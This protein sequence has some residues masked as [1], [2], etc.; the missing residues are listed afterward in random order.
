MNRYRKQPSEEEL[1]AQT[2]RSPHPKPTI[3]PKEKPLTTRV[4]PVTVEPPLTP[5][6]FAWEVLSTNLFEGLS[7]MVGGYIPQVPL[8]KIKS[9]LF[10]SPVLVASDLHK[11]GLVIFSQMTKLLNAKEH[12]VILCGDM[13]G[14][15]KRGEDASITPLFNFLQ[16]EYRSLH[17]VHGNH[18]IAETE[19]RSNPDGS[20]CQLDDAPRMVAGRRVCGVSGV[21]GTTK[22]RHRLLP[23]RFVSRV[24]AALLEDP[25]NS[26]LCTHETPELQVFTPPI[27]QEML[28][29]VVCEL[30][31]KAHFFGHC[32]LKP[33]Q[34][35]FAKTLF[36]NAD[37]RVLWFVPH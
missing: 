12:D 35:F 2:L 18:D 31:P 9:D 36:V 14:T 16:R 13:A 17:F 11:D 20:L 4:I 7:P 29:K 8:I 26:I 25:S 6:P 5:I 30:A 10:T 34:A 15:V 21:F 37:A 28:S 23:D 22:K 1:L 24:R 33:A 3:V 27:G 19:K 32:H